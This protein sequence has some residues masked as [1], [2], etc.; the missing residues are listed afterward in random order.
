MKFS[1]ISA[2]DEENGIGKKNDL[3]WD[4]RA[5]LKHFS[6][7]TK[8]AVVIMGLNTW[9]S[10]PEAHR[11]LP[12]RLNVVLSFEEEDLPDG[13][14]QARSFEEAFEKIEHQGR[15]GTTYAQHPLF[16][17][18]GGGVYKQAI[19]MEEC[20]RL[21]LTEVKGTHGCDIFFPEVDRDVWEKTVEGKWQTE[22]DEEFRFTE[23]ERKN[24]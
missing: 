13:V 4:I 24:S 6:R 19:V 16:V 5:D 18:G 3:A 10:L 17:I 7:V 22:G 21:Y 14:L 12:K 20:E 11:P 1:I 23:H 2:V 9:I 15:A 8:G